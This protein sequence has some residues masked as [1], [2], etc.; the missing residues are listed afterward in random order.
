M[1][2][3]RRSKRIGRWAG[4]SLPRGRSP[5]SR[6]LPGGR[7]TPPHGRARRRHRR[8]HDRR[9]RP[10]GDDIRVVRAPDVRHRQPTR[11]RR[12]DDDVRR[13][14]GRSSRHRGHVPAARQPRRR[15][16]RR[17]R[18]F[19]RA[20]G[21]RADQRRRRPRQRRPRDGRRRTT[22]SRA[23]P[24]TTRSTA[25]GGVDEYFGETGDDTIEARDGTAERIAC[26]AGNDEAHN[27]FTDIIAECERGIDADARRLQ[28]APSTAT[29]P[30]PRS[31]RA[32]RRS[33]TTAST[34]TATAATT[35]TSTSTA[36]A[37]RARSTATTRNAAIRP[38][39]PE[40]RGNAVDENCDKRAPS[41]SPTS[42][43]SSPTSGC[44]RR[45]SRGCGSSSSTT[46]PKGARVT[47][48]LH[49]PQLP[50]TPHARAHRPRVLA[51]VVLHRPFRR[52]AAAPR[53]AAAGDD[54]RRRDDRAHL[55]LHRQARRA[56]G[57]RDRL[58]RARRAKGAGRAE[59]RARCVAAAGAAAARAGGR[60]RRHVPGRR[61]D[62][63]LQRR[64]RRVDQIAGFDTG[65]SIRFTRFGGAS[66][67]RRAPAAR[68]PGRPERRLPQGG[69]RRR[70]CS[71]SA[72]ATTS[73]RSAAT[74]RPVIFNGGDG[75]DGLFGGGGH[76]HLQR[77]RRRRQHRL[78]RRRAASRSTA[79]SGN[80]TAISDDADTRTSCEE[81]EGDADGDGV[82]R[83]ADCNDANP[84]I[85]PGRDRHARRRHRPGLR[86][87]RRDQ[88]RRA[89]ATA[90]PR[91]QD[92]DDA[93]PAI[94]PGARE[95]VGN[96][97]DENC[98]TR[99][100]RVPRARRR[101]SATPGRRPARR[102][103]NRTLH[104]P[105]PPARHADRAALL[106]PGLPV[107][108]GRPPGPQ[109]R[110]P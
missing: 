4:A 95:I 33:S 36:T 6:S 55:H 87:R 88:P 69:R 83:P 86:R 93:N 12:A 5:G 29:T 10:G 65:T 2:S 30:T 99:A 102:T 62:D 92:C 68:S 71:T 48:P 64:R 44:S 57:P 106:R 108:A 20:H 104:G 59:A 19:K 46:R 15:P 42:A 50:V 77:R 49:R 82:R 7:R 98:D 60:A 22:C 32:R 40:I 39:A 16:R 34:R 31:S 72:T 1:L 78:P 52:R 21:E 97:V 25:R 11:R 94:K 81:I 63:R 58:P 103:V 79:A 89:T 47:L 90:S 56:A 13:A 105:R 107:P 101:R 85:R 80:D 75:N 73:P 84:A 91:P 14:S 96:A 23:A 8:D 24:A 9:R 3:A 35:R 51:P 43:P 100:V 28:H 26:G 70:W 53:H 61:L 74:S 41:R 54:H 45:R 17:R 27:D 109:R 76:R 66:A 67:R 37:S 38:T 18:R 110:G